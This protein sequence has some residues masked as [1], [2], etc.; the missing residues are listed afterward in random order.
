MG[1]GGQ[2]ANSSGMTEAMASAQAAER[3]YQLGEQQLQWT[4]DVWN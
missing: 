4:K 1:K 3:A 2:D